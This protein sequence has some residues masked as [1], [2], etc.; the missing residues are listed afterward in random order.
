ME[1]VH[2]KGFTGKT[3]AKCGKEYGAGLAMHQKFCKGTLE[4]KPEMEETPTI[5]PEPEIKRYDDKSM[6]K[7]HKEASNT[8]IE[9]DETH[10]TKKESEERLDSID[11]DE[12]EDISVGSIIL[13]LLLGIVLAV[14]LFFREKIIEII[15]KVHNEE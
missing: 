6:D 1:T 4:E 9:P 12:E 10:K 7:P 8:K 2:K 5:E 14:M 3:C 11:E 15:G 13:L